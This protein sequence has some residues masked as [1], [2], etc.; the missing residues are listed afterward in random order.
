MKQK[1]SSGLVVG[2]VFTALVIG[3]CA[4][5]S[6]SN[7]LSL[8][9]PNAATFQPVG[10]I[11][12][13]VRDAITLDP[14]VGATVSVGL[15][16]DVTDAEGQ[17]IL[18]NVPATTDNLAGTIVGQYDMTIDLT[19]AT[20]KQ[21][22]NG[23]AITV[24][25]NS[26]ASATN[27]HFPNFTYRNVSVGFTSLN[28]SS[29]CPDPG[30]NG[31]TNTDPTTS[32]NGLL[33][34]GTNATNHDTPVDHLVANADVNVGKLD[35]NIVGVVAGGCENTSDKNFYLLQA[36]YT[37]KLV[38]NGSDNT[39]SG[40]SGR[41][42]ATTTT[43]DGTAAPL[44]QF[45]FS[46]VEAGQSFSIQVSDSATNP[47]FV[48]S[49]SVSGVSD[50]QTNTQHLE[51]SNAI[52]GGCP[53][54]N[55]GPVITTVVPQPGSD[56]TP[57]ATESVTITFSEPIVQTSRTTTSQS[58][59]GGLYNSV[60]VK[61]DGPKI[62]PTAGK[63][64]PFTLSWNATFDQLTAQFETGTSGLYTVLFSD[65]TVF[66]DAYGINA[67][68]GV[69]PNGTVSPWSDSAPCTV[70]FSTNG[71]GA[72]GTT[73]T[74]QVLNSSSL[75]VGSTSASF[76]WSFI[77]GAKT[78]NIY[79]QQNEVFQDGTTQAGTV[80]LYDSVSTTQDTINFSGPGGFVESGNEISLQYACTVRGVSSDGVE[81]GDS[82]PAPV[83]VKD[84]VGPD[85]TIF[86][87]GSGNIGPGGNGRLTL[88]FTEPVRESDAETKGDYVLTGTDAAL[89]LSTPIYNSS[90][91]SVQLDFSGPFTAAP[92]ADTITVTGVRDIAGNTNLTTGGTN[93]LN[94]P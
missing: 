5:G 27:P 75:N 12:G 67:S 94:F 10:T 93:A 73:S 61:F 53:V 50:G 69:C 6:K 38:S 66:K 29:P 80:Q 60:A 72:P 92:G 2:L 14:I 40:T 7:D 79:C 39:A 49:G 78:Y 77:S 62:N 20:S 90:N 19:H 63:P 87:P 42:L 89:T 30:S 84:N 64:V 4:K 37:V 81:G 43:G 59:E 28:D 76:D 35:A 18:A 22:I 54:N 24:N 55:D 82:T 23:Q 45:T 33:S 15:K 85:F 44:G 36:G 16:S 88:Q 11:Q 25:M 57:S 65:M 31:N 21:I 26:A 1:W 34:C 8:T 51:L 52:H 41:V 68:P 71:G 70:F 91:S 47:L 58:S 48:G 9:N 46:S 3:G 32:N 74:F 17:Y 56:L 13:K 83:A 86:G